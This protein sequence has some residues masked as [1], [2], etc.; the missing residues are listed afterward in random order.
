MVGL[1]L[2][3]PSGYAINPARDFGPRLF[4]ALF[5]TTGLFGDLYWLI[6]PILG[7][8]VGGP[9]GVILYDIFIAPNLPKPAVVETGRVDM[10]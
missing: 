9:L 2:G 10:D 8:L 6:V 7:P 1:T 5:G 3:G 4:G